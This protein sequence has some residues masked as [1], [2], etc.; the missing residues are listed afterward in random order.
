[1]APGITDTHILP[2]GFKER[3]DTVKVV[4]QSA[5]YPAM[6]IMYLHQTASM[7]ARSI[8]VTNQKFREVEGGYEAAA[9]LMYG[10]A[11]SGRDYRSDPERTKVVK[12]MLQTVV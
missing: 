10:D 5:D 12:E 8:L 6:A 1:M 4:T 11:G 7:H 3:L 9:G 2:A